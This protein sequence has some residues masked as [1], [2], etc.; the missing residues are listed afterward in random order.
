MSY[1]DKHY[2]RER[3]RQCRGMAELASDPEIRRRHEDLAELHATRV[4]S[5]RGSGNG[6]VEA[7]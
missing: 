1:D 7:I 2:H 3:E 5:S 6:S 4:A